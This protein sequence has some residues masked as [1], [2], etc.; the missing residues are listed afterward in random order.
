MAKVYGVVAI[1]FCSVCDD[2]YSCLSLVNASAHESDECLLFHCDA[3]WFMFRNDKCIK[4]D[5]ADRGENVSCKNRYVF[6][7]KLINEIV[8][9][10]P[11]I[12]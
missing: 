10:L 5:R 1:D 2:Q 4:C 3:W 6:K 9:Y 8:F 11:F 7:I 12:W